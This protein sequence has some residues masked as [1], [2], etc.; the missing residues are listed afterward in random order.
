MVRQHVGG[1]AVTLETLDPS[2]G[3]QVQ[4]GPFG[5]R[6]LCIGDVPHQHVDEGVLGIAFDRRPPFS[7]HKAHP[8]QRVQARFELAAWRRVQRF[9][10][11]EPEGASEHGGVLQQRL[12]GR[13]EPVE[14]RRDHALDRVRDLHVAALL[15]EHQSELLGVQRVATGS[16][17]DLR[18]RVGHEARDE[19]LGLDVG[20]RRQ[21]QRRRVAFPASPAAS[22]LE[23]LGPRAGDDQDGHAAR[24]V[25]QLIDKVEERIVGPLEVLEDEHQRPHVGE[26]LEKAPPCD[27]CLSPAV[28]AHVDVSA[29]PHQRA[30]VLLEPGGVRHA[31]QRGAQLL[32]RR[33]GRVVR[34]DARVVPHDLAQSPQAHALAVRQRAAVPPPDQVAIRFDRLEQLVDQAALADPRLADERDELGGF[35][36]SHARERVHQYVELPPAADEGRARGAGVELDPRA[37]FER[38]ADANRPGLALD[39]D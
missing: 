26:R 38:L 20:Q 27:E 12:V 4:V 30:Q 23:Q 22:P 1:A 10:G 15:G 37:G 24:P 34:E 8:G 5:A 11:A 21:R 36:G 25:G 7:A 32:G 28:G 9:D 18:G 13:V 31:G 2:R 16:R 17:K 3:A 19:L 29:Q 39:V 33:A 6:N 35:L 14:P